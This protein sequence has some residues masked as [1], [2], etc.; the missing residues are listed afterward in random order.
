MNNRIELR[1]ERL[2]LRPFNMSDVDDVL[3][4]NNDPEWAEYQTNMQPFPYTRKDIETQVE[5][6]SNPTYWE[7]GH[8]DLPS[9]ANGAGLLQ[10]FA[11]VFEKRVIGEIVVNQ[12]SNDKPNERVEIA[13]SL[14]R[15]Y[16]NKG[17]MTEASRKVIEWAFKTY[18]INQVYAW[19]DPKNIGSWRVMEKSGMKYEGVLR[20]HIKE[21]DEFRDQLY[22]GILRSEWEAQNNSV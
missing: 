20:S 8:P 22:Y 14:S 9:T 4:Y 6:F 18:N 5:M 1:T 21:K 17:L 2:L 16:W 3:E 7:K 19:C 11:L 15:K 10:I 13:Y 12:R